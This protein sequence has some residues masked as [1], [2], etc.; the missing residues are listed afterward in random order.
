MLIDRQNQFCSDQAVTAAARSTDVID[1]TTVRDIGVGS[2]IWLHLVVTETM[3]DASDNSTLAVTL[4]T[5]DNEA[6]SSA[7]TIRTL[8]TIPAVTVAGT[9]Y[10]FRLEPGDAVAYQRYL[11]LY[12]TPANGDLSAGKF[13]AQLVLDVADQTHYPV[14][15]SIL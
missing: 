5:D 4:I 9:E 10:K 15:F 6:M 14:G 13:S 1:L 3:D 12:F 2:N 7:A 11:G 8:V